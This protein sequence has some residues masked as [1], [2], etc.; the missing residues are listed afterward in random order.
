S[1]RMGRAESAAAIN[2]ELQGVVLAQGNVRVEDAVGTPPAGAGGVPRQGRLVIPPSARVVE[3]N[4]P[5]LLAD[6]DSVAG[7]IRDVRES[8]GPGG[9]AYRGDGTVD[10]VVGLAPAVGVALAIPFVGL[11]A[12]DTVVDWIGV[13]SGLRMLPAARR[14]IVV[15][16]RHRIIPH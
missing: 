3:H 15:L 8:N 7:A 6:Q 16:H 5:G 11:G 14:T 13:G 1:R 9:C 2:E 12:I 10:R 4:I